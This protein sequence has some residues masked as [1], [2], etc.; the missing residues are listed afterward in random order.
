MPSRATWER[1]KNID[2]FLA[3]RGM[4]AFMTSF[5]VDE[6]GGYFARQHRA[7]EGLA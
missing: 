1:R 7:W 4:T 3:G 6:E 5:P 2:G